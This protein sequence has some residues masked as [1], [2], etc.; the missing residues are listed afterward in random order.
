MYTAHT[1]EEY[2]KKKTSKFISTIRAPA[3]DPGSVKD[4]FIVTWM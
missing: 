1:V 4:F 2:L 3:L